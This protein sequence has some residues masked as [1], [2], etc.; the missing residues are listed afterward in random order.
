MLAHVLADYIVNEKFWREL[1]LY[2]LGDYSA[3]A[4][5]QH[6]HQVHALTVFHRGAYRIIG[7][8]IYVLWRV[9]GE[10]NVLERMSCAGWNIHGIKANQHRDLD[11]AARVARA[12]EANPALDA[13][14]AALRKKHAISYAENQIANG[15]AALKELT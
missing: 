1:L 12:V 10:G 6:D 3:F 14:V 2:T 7:L 9:Q 13:A 11:Q 5:Y 15:Q 8:I 4:D